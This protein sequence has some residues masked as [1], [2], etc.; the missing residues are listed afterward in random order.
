MKY[1]SNLS[2]VGTTILTYYCTMASY[3]VTRNGSDTKKTT[4]VK[5]FLLSSANY[6]PAM[7]DSVAF[8]GQTPVIVFFGVLFA[9]N[10]N[11]RDETDDQQML[12]LLRTTPVSSYLQG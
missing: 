4:M 12:C 10:P 1:I 11:H 5:S 3:A 8:P 9:D 2:K 7:K 6:S